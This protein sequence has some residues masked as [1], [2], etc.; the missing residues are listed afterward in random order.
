MKDEYKPLLEAHAAY[1]K[2]NRNARIT[3]EGNTDERGSREYNPHS[4]K[5]AQKVS[6]VY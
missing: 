4:A 5:S 6:S 3:V 2:S 1:L